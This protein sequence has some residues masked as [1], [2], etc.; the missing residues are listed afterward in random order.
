MKFNLKKFL[1]F[2]LI[3][4]MISIITIGCITAAFAP[5]ITKKMNGG[6]SGYAGGGGG[7][8]SITSGDNAPVGDGTAG[9]AGQSYGTA[10]GGAGGGA[11]G[12]WSYN[13]SN[14]NT[15]YVGGTGSDGTYRNTDNASYVHNVGGY[16]GPS[17]HGHLVMSWGAQSTT[18]NGGSS[19]KCYTVNATVAPETTCQ[20]VVGKNGAE[21]YLQ[22]GGV[23]YSS[24]SGTAHA[25]SGTTGGAGFGVSCGTGIYGKGG[26]GTSSGTTAGNAGLVYIKM[27]HN[28]PNKF[29]KI[30]T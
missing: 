7:A 10:V 15:A 16:C 17:Q 25:A 9:E 18:G 26:D 19:G 1:G 4:L 20:V 11:G 14:A 8:F 6:M 2:S 3:E 22:C 23:K 13:G 5:V 27:Q 30:K 12:A 21:T 29:I 28:N 24:N